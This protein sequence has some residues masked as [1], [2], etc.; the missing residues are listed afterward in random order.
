MDLNYHIIPCHS[1]LLRSG[2]NPIQCAMESFRTCRLYYVSTYKHFDTPPPDWVV[3]AIILNLILTFVLILILILIF[4]LIL[5]LILIFVL[6]LIFIFVLIL[7]L[8]LILTEE[9]MV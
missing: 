9:G 1:M 4:V 5:T 6:I 7:I 3:E 8:I 2:N